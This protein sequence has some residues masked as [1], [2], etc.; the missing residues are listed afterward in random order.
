MNIINWRDCES[1]PVHGEAQERALIGNRVDEF[2]QGIRPPKL[3]V[4][5]GFVFF[6]HAVLDLGKTLEIHVG[7]FEEIYYIIN[8]KGTF[9]LDDGVYAVQEGDAIFVPEG[10]SHGL[11]N[12]GS[13]PMEYI[14]A[15]SAVL[16]S[17]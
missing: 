9:Q 16:A 1:Y 13:I 6:N 3:P 12:S 2:N 17:R 5:K 8:G 7:V 14:V 10:V 15:G 11:I 4:A